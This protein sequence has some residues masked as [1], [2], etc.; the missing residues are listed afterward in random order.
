MA[1]TDHAQE[2][3]AEGADDGALTARADIEAAATC[4]RRGDVEEAGRLADRAIAIAT[5]DLAGAQPELARGPALAAVV[6]LR[7][8]THEQALALATRAM[9]LARRDGRSQLIAEA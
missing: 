5:A 9:R 3:R 4:L 6:M 1:D 7:V 8:G 2:P